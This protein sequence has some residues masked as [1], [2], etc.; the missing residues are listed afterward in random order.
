MHVF[1]PSPSFFHSWPGL[2]TQMEVTFSPLK[3]S[4]IKPLKRSRR[5]DAALYMFPFFRWKLPLPRTRWPEQLGSRACEGTGGTED[6]DRGLCPESLR[7]W[8]QLKKACHVLRSTG[9]SVRGEAHRMQWCKTCCKTWVQDRQCAG[10]ANEKDW[11]I[12]KTPGCQSNW[13]ADDKEH[14]PDSQPERPC[15]ICGEWMFREALGAQHGDSVTPWVGLVGQARS[16]PLDASPMWH[17]QPLIHGDGAE[18]VR[19]TWQAQQIA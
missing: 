19:G 6:Y 10:V 15:D 5:E 16:R 3:R 17:R 4:R 12:H 9:G 7:I 14:V 13:V 8:R 11:P 18:A 2:I 1:L